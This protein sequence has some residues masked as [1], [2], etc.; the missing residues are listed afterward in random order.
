MFFNRNARRSLVLAIGIVAAAV[1]AGGV[2]GAQLDVW[3]SDDFEA[4]L[5]EDA[6]VRVADIPAREGL[7][8]RAVFVQATSTGFLCLWDASAATAQVK[9]GGCN[10]AE[11]PLAGRKLTISLA[12]DGGPAVGDISDA[13]L[14]GLAA[15]EVT[16]IQVLMTDGTRRAIPMRRE[17]AFASEAGRFRAFAYRFPRSDFR[18]GVGPT[19][20]IGLNERGAEIERLTTGYGS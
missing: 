10:R 1:L 18:R 20:V 13:R 12:Y 17:L 6:S 8:A 16:S 3:P 7:P 4:S 9:Q 5:R 14:I 2:V 15:W 19:A 11:D